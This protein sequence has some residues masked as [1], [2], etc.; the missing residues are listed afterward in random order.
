MKNN[1]NIAFLDLV[2]LHRELEEE[3]VSVFRSALRT[4]GFIG[5]PMVEGFESDFARFCGTK[6]CVGAASGTDAMRFALMAA[7]VQAGDLVITVPNTFIA[8]TEA[9]SQAGALPAFVDIIESTCNMD[10]EKLREYLQT[11]C[12][13][14][15][16]GKPVHRETG[17]PVTAVVPVHLY[18]R[19]ADMD[20]ILELAEKYG[21]I[22]IEDACQAHGAEY[23]SERAKCWKKAGS[24]G[25]AAAFSF[26][27]SKNLGACGEAGAVTTGDGAIAQKIRMIRDHGQARKYYHDIEGYNGRLDAI[28]AG[29]L[30]VK[31]KSL[32]DWN[33]ARRELAA[34][35][36]EKLANIQGILP[37]LEARSVKSVYHLYV[38]RTERPAQRDSLQ[39]HLAQ[40]GVETGL[41]YP[42]PL[43]LQES[44]RSMN[45]GPGSFPVSESVAGRLLSLPMGPALTQSQVERVTDLIAAFMDAPPARARG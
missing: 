14:G 6:H 4:A 15:S 23:Y 7:G 33:K 19:P 42:I 35:Y 2:T 26:Y 43:H 17:R 3:L 1:G 39:A 31:L 40:G 11:R 45:L 13:T 36:G 25:A 21:L 20:P 41:H 22:V 12:E 18:G 27:P 5:G 10:P 44:Y 16:S 37:P 8:T 24:I 34:L 32:P 29:I 38:I 30:S 9:I 28:Q